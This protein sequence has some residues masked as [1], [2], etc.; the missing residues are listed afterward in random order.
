ML[1]TILVVVCVI[2]IIFIISSVFYGFDITNF[3]H[4]I[5]SNFA[6]RKNFLASPMGFASGS[7]SEF[8]YS[9]IRRNRQKDASPARTFNFMNTNNKTAQ[10]SNKSPFGL[11]ENSSNNSPYIKKQNSATFKPKSKF[12]YTIIH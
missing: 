2:Q 11:S 10:R 1:V 7:A 8:S 9:I 12:E 3:F 5:K 6:K 4:R